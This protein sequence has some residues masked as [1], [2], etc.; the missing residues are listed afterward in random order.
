VLRHERPGTLRNCQP[1]FSRAG[2]RISVPHSTTLSL[3]NPNVVLLDGTAIRAGG[4]SSNSASPS[5]R[6]LRRDRAPAACPGLAVM[7]GDLNSTVKQ[8]RSTSSPSRSRSKFGAATEY[9]AI[10]IEIVALS[11]RSVQPTAVQIRESA[12][13]R[14]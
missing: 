4:R 8:N 6:R 2:E 9:G 13:A 11:L 14:R 7:V 1:P 10:A 5:A 12:T 3:T